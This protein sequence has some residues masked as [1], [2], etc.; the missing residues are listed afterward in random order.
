MICLFQVNETLGKLRLNGNKIE[1]K[2]GMAIA[3]ALQVNTMLE[4]LDLAETDQVI[5]PMVF[6]LHFFKLVINPTLSPF[7][8]L[9]KH[10]AV[11]SLPEIMPSVASPNGVFCLV[12]YQSRVCSDQ[13]LLRFLI[14]GLLCT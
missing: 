10:C 4:E 12:K 8:L 9:V 6:I 1:N 7:R 14:F 2:G 5:Y 13:P 3:G 11:L